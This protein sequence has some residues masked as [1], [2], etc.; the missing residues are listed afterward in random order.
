MGCLGQG[1][2]GWCKWVVESSMRV[3]GSTYT[4]ARRV[5]T[6]SFMVK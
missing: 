5:P 2:A 1:A 4:R 6:V 3:L